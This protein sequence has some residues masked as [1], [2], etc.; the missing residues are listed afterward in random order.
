MELALS[1]AVGDAVE[2]AYARSDLLD[3]RR[4]LMY[5]WAA[6]LTGERAKV[7]ALRG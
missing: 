1:H 5:Q 7:V 3:K 2:R 6:Y 4:R